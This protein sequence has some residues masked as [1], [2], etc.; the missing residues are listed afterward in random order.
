MKIEKLLQFTEFINKFRTIER[1]IFIHGNDRQEN[2]SEHSFNLALLAWFIV[3]TDK[4]D[5]DLEKVIT[6]S[7]V[8]DLVEIYSGD[9]NVFSKDVQLLESKEKRE[10]DGLEKMNEELVYFPELLKA[11]ENYNKKED[12]ESK[13]VYALDK[14]EPVLNIYLN[15]GRNWHVQDVSL[16]MILAKKELVLQT[17]LELKEYWEEL[18]VLLVENKEKLF[19]R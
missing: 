3:S 5:F 1:T 14:I 4:L 7:L 15:D 10:E 9:T 2:D 17:S 8:H 11:I 13:F 18:K 12:K 19:P 6:Y 16:E